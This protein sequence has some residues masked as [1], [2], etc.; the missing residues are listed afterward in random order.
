MIGAGV[1][2]SAGF[3]A[4]DLDPQWI[5]LAWVVGSIIALAGARAYGTLAQIVPRSG[6][7]YRYL[8]DLLHPFAGYAAGWTSL[9]VGFAAPIALDALVAGA[10]LKI[11]LPAVEPLAVAV[12]LIVALTALHAARLT[13][14]R[15]TQNVLVVVKL[16]L[17]LAFVF[18]GLS[19]G[20]MDWPQWQAPN[21]TGE[22]PLAPFMGSLFFIAFAFSGWNAAAYAAEEFRSPRDVSRAMLIGCAFVAVLYLILNWILVANL[23]PE[24]ATVVFTYETAR[25]TLGHLVMTDLLG[26]RG[27]AV[28]SVLIIVA[29]ISAMS[30]MILAGPRVYAAMAA[31]GFLPRALRGREGMPPIGSVILQGVAA[32]IIVFTHEVRTILLSIGA[33]LTLFS[34]LTCL[35]LI[36]LWFRPRALPKPDTGSVIA[37]AIHFLAGV[38]MLYFGFRESAT[39][40]LWVAAGAGAAFVSYILSRRRSA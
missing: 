22:F 37:A 2:L 39:L 28:M 6:G 16:I 11:L 27:A 33:I 26:A 34:A 5:L 14:S 1:F 7:E 30:A 15:R 8:S 24:R 17:I 20:S 40:L 36:A 32:L 13:W 3:M 9:L 19:L 4:Q 18:I 23:T 10:F 35:S 31:D 25:I 29:F 12:A 38:W 21:R